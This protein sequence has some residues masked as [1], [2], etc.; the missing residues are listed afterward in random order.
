MLA[1]HRGKEEN[2]N[3]PRE[4]GCIN[5]VD[6]VGTVDLSV[7]IDDGRSTSE[8]AVSSNLG[9]ANPVVGA[10]SSRGLWQTGNILFNSLVGRWDLK[11]DGWVLLDSCHHALDT[12]NDGSGI[13]IVLEVRRF[14]YDDVKCAVD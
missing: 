4:Y 3:S 6:V 5:D 8:P 14:A 10:T 12:S 9:C 13:G 1:I 7:Q 2:G 11:L